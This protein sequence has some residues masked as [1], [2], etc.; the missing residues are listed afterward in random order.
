VG[1]IKTMVEFPRTV[2]CLA[3]PVW[4][5]PCLPVYALTFSYFGAKGMFAWASQSV[6]V[7]PVHA[8]DDFLYLN[9][10]VFVYSSF[11]A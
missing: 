5:H 11:A 3:F 6:D 1:R 2:T 4:P 7:S 9:V 8:P 10:G